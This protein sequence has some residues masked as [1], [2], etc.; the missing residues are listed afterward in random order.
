MN[1]D[2]FRHKEKEINIKELFYYI[3]LRWKVLLIGMVFGIAIFGTLSYVKNYKNYRAT[4]NMQE[5]LSEE[6]ENKLSESEV[7]YVDMVSKIYQSSLESQDRYKN[8]Y[9]ANMDYSAVHKAVLTYY[10]KNDPR[11]T[12]ESDRNDFYDDIAV[13]YL[14]RLTS[15]EFYDGITRIVK[16]IS[17]NQASFVVSSTVD[18]HI[19]TVIIKTSSDDDMNALSAYAK[20]C[21][22][23]WQNDL[24][25]LI[26]KH[27]IA[28]GS[29]YSTVGSDSDINSMQVNYLSDL[30]SQKDSIKNYV[31]RMNYN[32]IVLLE[33]NL[34]STIK[35]LFS[36]TYEGLG[37][38]APPTIVEDVVKPTVNKKYLL[39]GVFFG[40]FVAVCC[41]S[42]KFFFSGKI[43][44]RDELIHYYGVN[45]LGTLGKIDKNKIWKKLYGIKQEK[46]VEAT[47][48]IVEILDLC[49]EKKN[50]SSVTLLSS[51]V[52]KDEFNDIV[53]SINKRLEND[54]IEMLAAHIESDADLVQA[55]KSSDTIIIAEKY[56]VS[57]KEKMKNELEF[58][59]MFGKEVLGCI[60]YI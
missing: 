17:I 40:I 29:E 15:E 13:A 50:I 27:E 52:K 37:L 19:I 53:V 10:I 16:D 36:L 8:S 45:I 24:Y 41:I 57:S 47:K 44:S 20:E 11:Y 18:H 23:S 39:I 9:L 32:Q 22:Q 28:L 38:S 14:D 4:A 56:S 2:K 31:G 46:N 1:S 55:I 51:G 60:M 54:G 43:E 3:L 59:R 48:D 33:H 25:T 26:G 49:V 12:N 6:A 5:D 35:E 7:D 30:N 34:N 21:M 42:C 58:C